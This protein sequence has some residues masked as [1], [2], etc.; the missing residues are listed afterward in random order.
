M[1]KQGNRIRMIRILTL[2]GRDGRPPGGQ[3]GPE[4]DTNDKNINPTWTGQGGLPAVKLDQNKQQMIRILTLPGRDWDVSWRSNWAEQDTN[5]KKINPTWTGRG[6]LLAVKLG[7]S[8]TA[9][10]STS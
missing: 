6:G 4:Q 2:P 8:R 9:S 7:W 10:T 1:V 5:Y 3:T